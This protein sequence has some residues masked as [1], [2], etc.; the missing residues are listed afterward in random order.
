[1][2]Q[3]LIILVN[4]NN[5]INHHSLGNIYE[6]LCRIYSKHHIY[7]LTNTDSLENLCS[8]YEIVD[9]ISYNMYIDDL[10]LNLN[11]Y[12]KVMSHKD[13]TDHLISLLYPRDIKYKH[14]YE[15]DN[16]SSYREFLQYIY[17][18]IPFKTIL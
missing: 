8:K 18:Y 12:C 11:I 10:K 4:S 5:F 1:M 7:T 17:T 3:C 15:I 9:L 2:K 14:I 16:F 6:Y 13:I